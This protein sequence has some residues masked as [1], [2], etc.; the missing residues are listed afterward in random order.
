MSI[1][2]SI[3][4]VVF[5]NSER[6][7]AWNR[8]KNTIHNYKQLTRGNPGGLSYYSTLKNPHTETEIL[9]FSYLK[10]LPDLVP[11]SEGSFLSVYKTYYFFI[12][13]E[14]KQC[15][16]TFFSTQNRCYSNCLR[17]QLYLMKYNN[18]LATQNKVWK[19]L[20]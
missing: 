6:S 16:C 13:K 17:N 12:F 7:A 3:F 5:I 1:D 8:P 18:E 11:I 4:S 20:T 14:S 9:L 19:P 10:I 15:P 2:T